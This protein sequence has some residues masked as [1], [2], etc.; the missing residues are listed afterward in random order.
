MSDKIKEGDES[1]GTESAEEVLDRYEADAEPFKS[2]TGRYLMQHLLDEYPGVAE[3]VIYNLLQN[4]WDNHVAGQKLVVKFVYSTREKRLQ[5]VASGYSG[6]NPKDWERY[7]ALHTEG[8]LGSI[9]RGEGGKVLV[10][11]AEVV[12]TET[13]PVGGTYLQALWR[14]NRIWRSDKPSTAR[15]FAEGFP[16]TAIKEGQTVITAAGVYDEIGDRSAGIEFEN[17]DRMVR[18]IQWNWNYLL[19]DHPGEVEIHY[20]VDGEARQVK[21]WPIPDMID[22][23]THTDIEVRDARGNVVGTL[24]RIDLGLAKVPLTDEPSPALAVCTNDHIVSVQQ[25]YGG[26]NQNKF[27]GRVV[28]DFLAESETTD[29]MRFKS[30]HAWRATR[31]LLAR[32]VDDFMRRHAGIERV[33]DPGVSKTMSEV[34]AQINRLVR[35]EFPD[36]HPEGGVIEDRGKQKIRTS[37]WIRAPKVDK[38][39]Y[40]PGQDCSVSFE[41]VNPGRSTSSARLEARAS[42]VDPTTAVVYHKVWPV[43]VPGDETRKIQ[44]TFRIPDVAPPGTYTGRVSIVDEKQVVLHERLIGFEVPE[45]EQEEEETEPGRPRIPRKTKRTKPKRGDALQT[46][47]LARIPEEEGKIFES[48]FDTKESRVYVNQLSASWT[49]TYGEERAQRYHV[50]KCQIDELAQIKL[51]RTLSLLEP[52]EMT[53]DR[54]IDVA[55]KLGLEKSTFMSK[56]SKV[57]SVRLGKLGTPLTP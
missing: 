46:P 25:V 10:P 40:D 16:P 32:M 11:I 13:H 14:G 9:R 37:P 53:K 12:R 29:H 45:V 36:W 51:E 30:T 43:D 54:L 31:D 7:N 39:S 50:A 42:F 24:S 19:Q 27:F 3:A 2:D 26:P 8:A 28:A 47:F 18:L 44:D 23:E 52:D 35:E 6:I 20:E 33:T 22:S 49:L 15:V 38:E 34:T 1:G 17:L 57:E 56:W 41:V 5:F 55:R 48:I 4:V 21:P